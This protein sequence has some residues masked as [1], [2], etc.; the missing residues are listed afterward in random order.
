MYYDSTL[1]KSEM[2]FSNDSKFFLDA[3]GSF[4]RL[5]VKTSLNFPIQFQTEII[6]NFIKL[7]RLA[8]NAS[9]K[10]LIFPVNEILERIENNAEQKIFVYTLFKTMFI[11][12]FCPEME[13]IKKL[14]SKKVKY[15]KARFVRLLNGFPVNFV[16][17]YS[18]CIYSA[19]IDST[20][21]LFNSVQED[22]DNY[23]YAYRVI[24][25]AKEYIDDLVAFM[26]HRT[27]NGRPRINKKLMMERPFESAIK[28][29][30]KIKNQ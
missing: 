15:H 5:S 8:P 20:E 29:A 4:V 25:V 2:I 22:T 3:N 30:N 16:T 12:E 14:N 11:A 13:N 10:N 21:V 1:I 6:N 9:T 7:L 23:V 24:L 18:S 19:I 27:N 17:N 26:E 28:L